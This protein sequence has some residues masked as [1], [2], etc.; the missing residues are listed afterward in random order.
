M[1]HGLSQRTAVA[2]ALMGVLLFSVGYCVVPAQ[3]AAHRCCSHMS[4]PCAPSS[5]NCCTA[6]PQIPPAVVTAAFSGSGDMAVAQVFLPA[7]DRSVS[8]DGVA[9]AVIPSHSPPPGILNLRI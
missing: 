9:P 2:I 4:M 7:S 5:T 3:H 1:L 6:S 8:R